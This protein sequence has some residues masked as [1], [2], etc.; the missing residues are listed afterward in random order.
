MLL[1]WSGIDDWQMQGFF[2]NFMNSLKKSRTE[3]AVFCWLSSDEM[4]DKSSNTF[5][6]WFGAGD[7][8]HSLLVRES[9]TAS[10]LAS[11][12]VAAIS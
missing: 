2:G 12:V 6:A 3:H 5:V 9:Q 7:W 4:K 1:C 8:T 11:A 10:P